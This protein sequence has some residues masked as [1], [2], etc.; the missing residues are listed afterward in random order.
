LQ[1]G[2]HF[3]ESK[4]VDCVRVVIFLGVIICVFKLDVK[5]RVFLLNGTTTRTIEIPGIVSLEV[6]PTS[7]RFGG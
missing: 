7:V 1:N 6:I 3:R 4:P 2:L 5:S